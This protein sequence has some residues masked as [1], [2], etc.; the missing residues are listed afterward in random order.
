MGLDP[1]TPGSQLEPMADAQ[2]LSHPG[3]QD[4]SI[5]RKYPESVSPYRQAEDWW[6]LGT[7]KKAQR[8]R[9]FP[10]RGDEMFGK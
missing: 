1:R 9:G 2:P 7:G 8:N 6:I 4:G 10:Y 5:Y 3:A